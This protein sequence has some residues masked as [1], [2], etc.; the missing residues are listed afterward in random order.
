VG[1]SGGTP[2]WEDWRFQGS[3][4]YALPVDG[5]GRSQPV[6]ITITASI[7]RAFSF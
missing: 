6:G 5:L 3:A 7:L 1:I 2:L 4:T